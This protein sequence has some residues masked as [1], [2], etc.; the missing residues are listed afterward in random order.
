[1]GVVRAWG[2][3]W[4]RESRLQPALYFYI[5]FPSTEE[6]GGRKGLLLTEVFVYYIYGHLYNGLPYVGIIFLIKIV[7]LIKVF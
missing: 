4:S 5:R 3:L 1:M 7:V 6:G 2:L